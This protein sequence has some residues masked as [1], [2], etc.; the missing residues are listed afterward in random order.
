MLPQVKS[1]SVAPF[2]DRASPQQ[3]VVAKQDGTFSKK[4]QVR[5]ARTSKDCGFKTSRRLK[6]HYKPFITTHARRLL[7]II[8]TILLI[9][10]V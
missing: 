5:E 9:P 2:W 6:R 3:V 8:N 1:L 7:Q 10:H 4:D